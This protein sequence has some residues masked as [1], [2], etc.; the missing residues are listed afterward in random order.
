MRI[1]RDFK[2]CTQAF[3]G[4]VVALGNFDGVHLGHQEIL[5]QCVASAKAYHVPA[6]VMTFEPHPREFFSKQRNRLRLGSFR[7]KIAIMVGLG[8]DTLFLVRFNQEFSSMSAESFVDDVL[9]RQLKVKHVVTGYNFAF[10]KGR[11]G[12]TDYLSLRGHQLGFGYTSCQPVQDSSGNVISSSFIR[13]LLA[14]GDVRRAAALLGAPYTIEG[15]VR[16]G[17]KRGRTIG[18]PTANISLSRLFKPRFGVYAVRLRVAGNTSVYEGVA[19]IGIKPTFSGSEALLEVHILG[20][21]LD[22][23]DA[24][25][26]VECIDFIRDE[27][28]FESVEALKNQIALDCQRA[29]QCFA[30]KGAV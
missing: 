18:F 23:Y 7:R 5:S 22:L 6:A 19:N 26:S 11:A 12:D 14:N 29:R 25:V 20:N 9:Y 3:Q 1:I 27:Q 21:T 10:G 24:H 16:H 17:E 30:A 4:A 28:R 15:R 2:Q 8:I 13:Q